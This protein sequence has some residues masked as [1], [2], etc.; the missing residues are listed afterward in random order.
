M[1]RCFGIVSK[2]IHFFWL[3]LLVIQAVYAGIFK[4]YDVNKKNI[5]RNNFFNQY[6]DRNCQYV[7]AFFWVYLF[8]LALLSIH[9]KQIIVFLL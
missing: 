5:P 7:I 6:P 1:W 3:A 8:T 2:R 4:Y 9:K